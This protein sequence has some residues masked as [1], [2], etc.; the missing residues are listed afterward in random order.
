MHALRNRS[1]HTECFN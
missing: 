1:D